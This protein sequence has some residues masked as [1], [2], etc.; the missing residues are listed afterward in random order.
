MKRKTNKNI[1]AAKSD[2]TVHMMNLSFSDDFTTPKPVERTNRG[3]VE[4]MVPFGIDNLF[5]QELSSLAFGTSLVSTI[6]DKTSKYIFGNGIELG[7]GT[8]SYWQNH[9]EDLEE[10]IFG[11][12]M[13]Y[14]TYGAFAT[15]VRRNAFGD[16]I[17]LDKTNVETLRTNELNSH[18]WYCKEWKK[19]FK[20]D[21]EIDAFNED[22]KQ[23]NSLLYYKNP[24]FNTVYGR[25]AWWSSLDDVVTMKALSEYGISTVNNAFCPSAVISL[26]EGKPTREE[27]SAVEKDLND[28]FCGVK[29]NAKLVVTFS[30][31]KD[32]APV[33][34]E[35]NP[36]DMNAHY[37]SLKDTTRDNI[38]AAFSVDPL[39]VGLRTTDGL[40]NKDNFEQ[41]FKLYN[42]TEIKPIQRQIQKA[43]A[44][45]GINFTFVPFK[46]NWEE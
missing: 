7:E 39:L 41:I 24:M 40:F 42:T 9:K 2:K 16:I 23:S 22:P 6:I 45:L 3:S 46:I 14:I 5:P 32:S 37:L 17:K 28:K 29:N 38:F 1:N 27:A 10:T 30:D 36:S 15:Q 12:I 11:N 44:R 25:A 8:S 13:D 20:V 4:S 21:A 18:F 33:I 35:F 19:W 34:H 43:Y 31:N 26:V